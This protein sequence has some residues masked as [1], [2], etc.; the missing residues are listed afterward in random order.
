MMTRLPPFR[1]HLMAWLTISDV[2]VSAD[3]IRSVRCSMEVAKR[4]PAASMHTCAPPG[5]RRSSSSTTSCCEKSIVRTPRCVRASCSRLASWSIS[6]TGSQP[7]KRAHMHTS[8]PTGPAPHTA[9]LFPGAVSPSSLACH[10]VGM[11]SDSSTASSL[12]RLASSF[13]RFTS[14]S[15]TRAYSACRPA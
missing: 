8:W 14:A 10:A 15:G 5:S 2:S 3:N 6:T 9:T 13:I 1:Q 12:G 4:K 11:M 7:R